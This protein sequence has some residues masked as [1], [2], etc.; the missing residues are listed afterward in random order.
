MLSKAILIKAGS[1]TVTAGLALLLFL[2]LLPATKLNAQDWIR[3]GTNRGAPIR[4]A[5]PD[6]NA[7]NADPGN[8]PL[9][10]VFN[11]T[12]W[13]DLDNAGI[14]EMVAKSFYPAGNPGSPND[15]KLPVWAGPP[16]N[17]AMVAFGN[18]GVDSGKVEVQGWLYDVKNTQAPQIL[19]K[20]YKEDATSDNAEL[21]LC[22]C[23]R[24][25][26]R[27]QPWQRS[28]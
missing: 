10:S 2:A 9:L 4:L 8:K 14:F 24:R 16:P 17:A 6:F 18:L 7:A 11:E 3:T 20:Q 19:G 21:Q 28:A 22:R 25:D 1:K 12:L 13:Y 15:I 23:P 5:V 26:Y 27:M